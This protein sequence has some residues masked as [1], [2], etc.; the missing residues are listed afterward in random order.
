[1][2]RLLKRDRFIVYPVLPVDTVDHN[3]LE[4]LHSISPSGSTGLM[5]LKITEKSAFVGYRGPEE[6]TKKKIVRDVKTKGD[7]YFNTGDLMKIDVDEY[8][9]FIDRLGDTF[10]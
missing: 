3:E 6:M 10:R 2:I 7:A 8:V 5:L 1:M 9:Y 4:M